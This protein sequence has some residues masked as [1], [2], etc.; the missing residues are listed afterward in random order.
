MLISRV[1]SLLMCCQV[2]VCPALCID[3]GASQWG[4]SFGESTG[5]C[6]CLSVACSCLPGD[7]EP[8]D[9][10]CDPCSDCCS[11]FCGG[12]IAPQV[13]EFSIVSDSSWTSA[14]SFDSERTLFAQAS[15]QSIGNECQ[16]H[17]SV[18]SGRELLL[19]YCILLI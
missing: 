15:S 13:E 5:S 19:A 2:M 10:P 1:L 6:D 18:L 12:A 9:A 4:C 8:S 7:N 17:D 14:V 16:S 3:F 11:C